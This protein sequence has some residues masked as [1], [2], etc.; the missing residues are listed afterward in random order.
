MA[1]VKV[2]IE[3]SHAPFG[4]ENTF[5]GLYAASA[6]LSKGMD[7]VVVMKGDGVYTGRTGQVEPQ[8]NISLP[9]TEE[10]VTDILELGGRIVTDKNALSIRGINSEELF[11]DI[12]I[13]DGQQI[14][15]LVLDHGDKVV[16]F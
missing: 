11:K 6:S 10:L 16:E 8:K 1:L 5:A 9:P 13:M 15:D 14:H 7:V 2:V 4:H 3:L 12:E